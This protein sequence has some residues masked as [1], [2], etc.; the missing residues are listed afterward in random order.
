[1]GEGLGFWGCLRFSGGFFGFR[2]QG[3]WALRLLG[4]RVKALGFGVWSLGF[5]G[6][7]M[8]GRV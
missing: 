5:R 8:A 1:M 2:A 6:S 4:F 3:L 7:L